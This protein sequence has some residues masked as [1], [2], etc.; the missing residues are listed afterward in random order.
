[1]HTCR[2]HEG[3]ERHFAH[4]VFVHDAEDA[5]DVLVV[6]QVRIG[7]YVRA[8]EIDASFAQEAEALEQ[9][10]ELRWRKPLKDMRTSVPLSSFRWGPPQQSLLTPASQCAHGNRYRVLDVLLDLF[11]CQHVRLGRPAS[12]ASL[13]RLR[14]NASV[15]AP[16]ENVN[17]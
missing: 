11:L 6:G 17:R 9:E 14:A 10:L 7:L 16:S 5:P 12:H 4:F 3:I 2:A 15:H 8:G 13:T 1:M